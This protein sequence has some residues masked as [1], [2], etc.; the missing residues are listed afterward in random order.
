MTGGKEVGL[1][2]LSSGHLVADSK[3]KKIIHCQS[4]L[5]MH[6]CCP[7]MATLSLV[8]VHVFKLWPLLTLSHE[9]TFQAL[10]HDPSCIHEVKFSISKCPFWMVMWFLDAL[11][12]LM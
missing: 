3:N 4:Q 1:L 2:V 6:M 9:S 5:I 12:L 8:I 7:D 11:T 10:S